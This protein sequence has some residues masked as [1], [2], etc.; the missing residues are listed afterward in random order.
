MWWVCER[1]DVGEACCPG[2]SKCGVPYELH[3][4]LEFC[5]LQINHETKNATSEQ[6]VDKDVFAFTSELPR[7]CLQARD[8]AAE[9][10]VEPAI[11]HRCH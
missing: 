9:V 8:E 2:P 7:D 1:T 10:L 6:T 4:T 11:R 5:G 3:F